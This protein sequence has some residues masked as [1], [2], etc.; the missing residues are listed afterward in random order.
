MA[1]PNEHIIKKFSSP[2]KTKTER[3]GKELDEAGARDIRSA[4]DFLT[5]VEEPKVIGNQIGFDPDDKGKGHTPSK[6]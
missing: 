5:R 4:N 2:D 1:I 3:A 6:G